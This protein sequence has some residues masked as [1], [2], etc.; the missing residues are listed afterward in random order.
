MTMKPKIPRKKA[1]VI[2]ISDKMSI[3]DIELKIK[4]ISVSNLL[5]TTDETPINPKETQR[6][7]QKTSQKT[8]MIFLVSS[9]RTKNNLLFELI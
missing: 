6:T 3:V 8:T 4:T 9:Q 7:S 2:F 5:P 1:S